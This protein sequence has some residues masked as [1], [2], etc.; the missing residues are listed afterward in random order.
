MSSDVTA[1][2]ATYLERI[3]DEV[4]PMMAEA[5]YLAAVPVWFNADLFAA[6]RQVEDGRN[7]G[8]IERLLRYSFVRTL[9]TTEDETATYTIRPDERVFLQRRWIARDRPAYLTAHQRA[10]AY[11]QNQPDPNPQR[12]R[13]LLLYHLLFVDQTAG[14]N[15]LIDSFRLYH[16]ERQITEIERLLDTVTDARFYLVVLKQDLTLLDDLLRHMWARVNQLRG[17]WPSSLQTLA[18][19]RAKPTLS[20][21]LRPYVIRAHGESLAQ[22]GQFVEAIAAYQE[23]LALFDAAEQRLRQP[24]ALEHALRITRHP[25]V[26]RILQTR[27]R[28]HLPRAVPQLRAAQAAQP[29]VEKQRLQAV[30]MLVKIR[31]LR[32]KA[33]RL[34]ARHLRA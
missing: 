25:P 29:A 10:L 33:H 1:T 3:L 11:W 16:K 14:I 32:Q 26:R 28:Q 17:L 12:Q 24:E 31:V 22:M 30:E 4:H 19:L 20:P 8:L 5:L 7:E 23:T 15:F 21:V 9:S 34:P 6:M 2:T 18:E 27:Q 13:R